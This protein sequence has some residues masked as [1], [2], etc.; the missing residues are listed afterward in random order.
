MKAPTVNDFK[1]FVPAQDF[2]V[3]TAFYRALGG[4]INWQMDGM[5]E[6]ELGGARFLLQD[7]YVKEWAEN[8]VIY[9]P[10]DDAAAWH[11]HMTRLIEAGTYPGI[12]VREPK[13]E[14]WGDTIT[15]A[16]D[17]SG[18]LIYFAQATEDER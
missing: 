14:P 10:V 7:F 13:Q 12:R 16:W 11:G 4:V 5:A 17:P 2:A 18:V 9:M 3:S 15:Y 8:F 1:V 6:F